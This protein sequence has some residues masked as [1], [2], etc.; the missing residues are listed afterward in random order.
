MIFS[1]RSPRHHLRERPSKCMDLACDG[2]QD[3]M[4]SMYVASVCKITQWQQAFRC[5]H[6][7]SA[8]PGLSGRSHLGG[9]L[10]SRQELHGAHLHRASAGDATLLLQRSGLPE[11]LCTLISGGLQHAV[12]TSCAPCRGGFSPAGCVAT[13]WPPIWN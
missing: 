12:Q 1:G 9:P 8:S 3:L 13:T 5:D 10:K 7:G 4:R 6:R 2:S 11:R